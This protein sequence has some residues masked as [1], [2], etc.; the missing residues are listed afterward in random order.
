M[1][2]AT[3]DI[4]ALAAAWAERAQSTYATPEARAALRCALGDA[5]HLC[6]ALAKNIEIANPG[7]RRG[8]VS[9]AGRFAA[10]QVHGAGSTIWRMRE[11]IEV[12]SS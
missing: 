9:T 6:D 5:A 12:P 11:L 1:T 4:S 10:W 8:S 3:T 2:T 7:R